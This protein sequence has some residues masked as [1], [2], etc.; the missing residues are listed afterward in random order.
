[1]PRT[2]N[3]VLSIRATRNGEVLLKLASERDGDMSKRNNRN[4]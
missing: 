2:K 3:E 1:M 4:K